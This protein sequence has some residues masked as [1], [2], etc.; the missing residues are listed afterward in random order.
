[1]IT[2]NKWDVQA[3]LKTPRP[4]DAVIPRFNDSY[5]FVQNIEFNPVLQTHRGFDWGARGNFVCVW[6]QFNEHDDRL[7]VIDEYIGK[8]RIGA[9]EAAKGVCNF[10][11]RRRYRNISSSY[12]DPSGASWIRDFDLMD[13]PVISLYVAK[14][15]RLD[16]LS[17]LLELRKDGFPGIIFSPRCKVLR[18]E[19]LSYD[20]RN[21][22]KIKGA[23]P[24]DAVDAL[25]YLLGGMRHK[26]KLI[27]DAA[28]G[29]ISIKKSQEEARI[30]K[31]S[32]AFEQLL[33]IRRGKTDYNLLLP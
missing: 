9:I 7:Y 10:E 8:P 21:L 23:S 17:K 6:V 22:K 29:V 2:Q 15:T 5:P 11:A 31:F 3:L 32:P 20:I 14:E 12:G 13:I 25:L 26:L 16:L 4:L 1:M 28:P 18:K 30:A 19:L 24:D 33:E 27:D